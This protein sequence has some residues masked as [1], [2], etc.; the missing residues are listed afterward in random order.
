MCVIANE[1]YENKWIIEYITYG[2]LQVKRILSIPSF[3]PGG[4]WTWD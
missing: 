4:F 3:S 1:L 2:I